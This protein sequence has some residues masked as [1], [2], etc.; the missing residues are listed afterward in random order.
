M[1]VL[2]AAVTIDNQVID[3]RVGRQ[4]RQAG[5]EFCRP[6]AGQICDLESGLERR[7]LLPRQTLVLHVGRRR[8]TD[9]KDLANL[10]LQI[11]DQRE[12]VREGRG[13]D[14]AG[15][16]FDPAAHRARGEKDNGRARKQLASH[17]ADKF[18]RGVLNRN[19]RVEAHVLVLEEEEVPEGVLVRWSPKTSHR[20]CIP[21]SNPGC[22]GPAREFAAVR[23][24]QSQRSAHHAASNTRRAPA[25]V[26]AP[27][28]P[29]SAP[30]AN[31]RS[32][33]HNPMASRK[34]RSRMPFRNRP[35]S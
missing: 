8:A 23:A 9:D 11:G 16:I 1:N 7:E 10:W 29:R 24:R 4:V 26:A 13:R 32:G 35:R 20:R 30:N 12:R 34:R 33:S 2:T 18:E 3:G 28:P 6:Q 27:T 14:E 19:D 17:A 5:L 15:R 25:S 31:G 21:S 22:R